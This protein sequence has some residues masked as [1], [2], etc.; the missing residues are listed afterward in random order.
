MTYG[1]GGV[2]GRRLG[3]LCPVTDDVTFNVELLQIY[4]AL[5]TNDCSAYVAGTSLRRC[6]L[7]KEVCSLFLR[8]LL[9]MF[10]S[11]SVLWGSFQRRPQQRSTFFQKLSLVTLLLLRVFL[12]FSK[13]KDTQ[14]AACS[15]CWSR[16]TKQF[17]L[18]D[19]IFSLTA[20]KRL[21]MKIQCDKDEQ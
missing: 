13:H 20:P 15:P 18:H 2:C 8:L 21:T 10:Y 7:R 6:S 9:Q 11:Q 1:V 19:F 16:E 14:S 4:L 5:I 3:H 17:S 12:P